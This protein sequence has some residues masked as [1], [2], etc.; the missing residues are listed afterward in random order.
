[1]KYVDIITIIAT[2]IL[3]YKIVL[4]PTNFVLA[5]YTVIIIRSGFYAPPLSLNHEHSPGFLHNYIF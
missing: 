3:K 5:L 4:D 2:A 1:M